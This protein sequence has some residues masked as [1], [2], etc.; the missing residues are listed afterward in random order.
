MHHIANITLA[1]ANHWDEL[2]V[3]VE[4]LPNYMAKGVDIERGKA[5]VRLL[6]YYTL[7]ATELPFRKGAKQ[8]LHGT[9]MLAL[10]KANVLHLPW[11]SAVTHVIQTQKE[12][13]E[14][15]RW[16]THGR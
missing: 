12:S 13:T 3:R 16:I 5:W 9:G 6:M 15:L 10:C 7:L 11:L 8:N 1:K 4:A 2:R 14:A